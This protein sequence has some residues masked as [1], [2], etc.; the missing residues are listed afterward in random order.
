MTSGIP[1]RFEGPSSLKKPY[2][3]DEREV[4]MKGAGIKLNNPETYGSM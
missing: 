4:M 1:H 3:V 2:Q